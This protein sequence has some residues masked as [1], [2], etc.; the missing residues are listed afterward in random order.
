VIHF[1]SRLERWLGWLNALLL[2]AGM[3]AVV[4]F[5]FFQALDR[6]T[7]KS[8]F[9]A[10]DQLAKVGLVWLV[11]AGTALGYAA[12]ENLRIDLFRRYLPR[13]VL[14]VREALFEAA[15]LATS[16]VIH[17]N[18]WAV[19]EVASFQQ[20]MGTPLTNAVPYATILLG[21][22]SIALTCLVRLLRMAAGAPENAPA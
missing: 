7:F 3:I 4:F 5:C 18:A 1:L 22:V 10:H 19:V 17:W 15:I 2:Y 11:Y 14:G 16:L 20:I 8:S 21:T 12:R 9:A 6:Y 13:A